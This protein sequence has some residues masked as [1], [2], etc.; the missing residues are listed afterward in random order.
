MAKKRVPLLVGY[1]TRNKSIK[2]HVVVRVW[3]PNCAREHLHGMKAGDYKI[4]R[5]VPHCTSEPWYKL[6]DGHHFDYFIR[7]LK[8]SE[9]AAMQRGFDEAKEIICQN[10]YN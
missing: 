1:P 3:C 6:R 5:R 7:Q 4:Q 2:G 10:E 8:P 9:F